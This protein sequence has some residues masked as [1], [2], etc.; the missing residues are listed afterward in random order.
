MTQNTTTIE[1]YID[2]I[3]TQI[4]MFNYRYESN[5][6]NIYSEIIRYNTNKYID[7]TIDPYMSLNMTASM[8]KM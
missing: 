3:I 8:W 5:N 6:I 1:Y 7:R 4:N 2:Y